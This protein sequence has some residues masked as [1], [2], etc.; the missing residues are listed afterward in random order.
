MSWAGIA[1]N[2]TV[3]YTN[4]KDAVDTNVFKPKTTQTTSNRE[5]TKAVSESLV[6]LNTGTAAW[7]ALT[8]NQLP[9]KS[10]YTP[11]TTYIVDIYAK[12]GT[13]S[14]NYNYDVYAYYDTTAAQYMGLADSDFCVNLNSI[15]VPSGATLYIYAVRASSPFDQVYIRGAN[16]STCPANLDVVCVYNAGVITSVVSRAITIY[17]DGS[18]DPRSCT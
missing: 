6:Y 18:G 3:S 17:I 1:S 10:D 11:A 15:I 5:V 16:S 8:S 13:A 7:T 12:W 9:V 2:Q 14:S 4:L